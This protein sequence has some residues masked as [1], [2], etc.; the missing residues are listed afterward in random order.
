MISPV[1]SRLSRGTG[2]DGTGRDGFFQRTTGLYHPCT[3]YTYTHK[4]RDTHTTTNLGQLPE[5]HLFR[6]LSVLLTIG[7]IPQ[8]FLTQD[9]GFGEFFQTLIQGGHAQKPTAFISVICGRG[10]VKKRTRIL[11]LL[12][13]VLR[14]DREAVGECVGADVAVDAVEVVDAGRHHHAVLPV[15]V[16]LPIHGQ[17]RLVRQVD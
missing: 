3:A 2:R 8:I 5:R 11:L 15:Q 12:F 1:P 13:L 17:E 7:T 4:H 9:F 6:G 14:S 16:V 10:G